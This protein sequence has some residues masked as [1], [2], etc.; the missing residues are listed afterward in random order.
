[1]KVTKWALL[2]GAAIAVTATAA[3]ADDLSALK[4]EI[5]A[6]Q[7]RV[8]QLEAQPQASMPSGY[9]LMAFRDG[10]GT[11]E[12]VLAER[13]SDKVREESGFTLSVL[14]TADVAP[15]AEVSVSG[16]I[17]TALIYTDD[18][19][20][21]KDDF[22]GPGSDS[23]D[24]SH[25]N[26]DVKVRGRI[27][28]KGKADTAV[29]EVGGYFRL[30]ADGGG[31]LSD[32]SEN[33]KMNKAYGWWKF[34]PEWELMAGY[35]DNTAALQ[36]GW[37]WLAATGPTN[38]F[39]PSNVNNEQMRLTFTSGP[40][41][42]AIALEDPD[43]ASGY[44]SQF[45]GT[46]TSADKSDLPN[47]QA[48]LMYSSD[49]FTAQV[50]GVVQEDDTSDHFGPGFEKVIEGGALDW[51]IGGGGTISI[52]EHFQ[53]TA[54]AVVGEGTRLYADNVSP[55]TN[56][57][58]FWAASLGVLAGLS[59]D[60]RLELGVGYEDYDEAGTAL[61]FGGGIYWDPVSQVTLGAGATWVERDRNDA[62][63]DFDDDGDI[64][65]DTLEVFFGTWLRFP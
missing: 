37:D 31:N 50:V 16:E 12:G 52:A 18:R 49:A 58:S 27:F 64:E 43:G 6:L 24:D 2:A 25:D 35:N 11:Y 42:F 54:G 14:P 20:E 30:Q 13:N 7:S 62:E 47:L 61:G 23:F 19:F 26:L 21:F 9:S 60:T 65:R 29:G 4:A 28:I 57:E 3:R 5:E 44:T 55:V 59:E 22:S 32:Y 8:S 33:T 40:L 36:V 38:S 15:A 45:G 39:G 17:R 51:A 63:F 48:Y 34:A 56:D 46:T 1:M 10:Q 41:S 53:V